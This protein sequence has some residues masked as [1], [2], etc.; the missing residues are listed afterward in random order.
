MQEEGEDSL[1]ALFDKDPEG[2]CAACRALG[3]REQPGADHSFAIELL[4]SLEILVQLWHGDEE[5]APRL[6]FLWDENATRYIRYETT[7]Y[8]AGLLRQRL[9]ES[10]TG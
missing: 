2:F 10:I 5:F 1:A 7:W 8:A 3:G 9:R 6:C 4:D